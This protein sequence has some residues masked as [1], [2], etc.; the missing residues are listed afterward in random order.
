MTLTTYLNENPEARTEIAN[1]H[2]VFAPFGLKIDEVV[3]CPQSVKYILK[4]P[5]DVNFQD[6]I[7]RAD[8]K[9]NY[10]LSSAIQNAEYTYG[11]E[12]DYIYI[13]RPASFN[14]V[15]FNNFK[16]ILHSEN[17]NLAVGIDRDGKAVITNLSN[18]PHILVAGTTGSGKS[19]LLHSF[20]ASL[21]EG[22]WYTK[23]EMLIID[24]KR[25]EFSA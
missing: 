23:V 2:T 7:R 20:V 25:A 6:K 11:H 3:R 19:E 8:K 10:A 4:M 22:M 1:I 18:A 24:P 13:E 9:I 15:S 17:L 16:G 14:I 5:L 12:N 21:I